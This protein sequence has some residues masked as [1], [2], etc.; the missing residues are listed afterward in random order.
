MRRLAVGLSIG[1]SAQAGAD[2]EVTIS[3]DRPS[4]AEYSPVVPRG[5]VQIE[6]GS[7]ATDNAGQ[8]TLDLPEALVR[9]GL[10]EG[11][12]LRLA[13]PNYFRHLPVGDSTASGFGDLGLGVKQQL[14]PFA[15]FNLSLIP[16]LTLPTG[17]R[18]ISSGGYDPGLQL[19]WSR[20]LSSD[21]TVAG[22]LAAYWP[23]ED[24]RRNYTSEI[25]ALVDWQLSVPWDAFIEYA[26]DIP[27]RGG[28]RQLLHAGTAYKLAPHHQ[29]DFHAAVGLTSAAPRSFLGVGYSYLGLT[30]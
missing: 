10:L 2:S 1:F 22:Q 18:G 20:A 11:T 25:T 17:A 15:G 6:S 5:A 8:W 4:V 26:A 9:Y 12:E 19:P 16:S 27:Q 30:R 29:I 28:S 24:G 13:L 7:Q 14:R 23:T 21:W 3:T